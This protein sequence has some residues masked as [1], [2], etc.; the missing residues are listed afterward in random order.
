M[1]ILDIAFSNIF[2]SYPRNY[3]PVIYGKKYFFN[4]IA[5]VDNMI[6]EK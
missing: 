3:V 4:C 1:L 2:L 6:K 5:E